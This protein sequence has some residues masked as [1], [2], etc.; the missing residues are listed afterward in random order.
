[1]HGTPRSAVAFVQV[2]LGLLVALVVP[3]LAACTAPREAAPA[4]VAAA[5]GAPFAWSR[6]GLP[7]DLRSADDVRAHLRRGL[8]EDELE[9]IGFDELSIAECIEQIVAALEQERLARGDPGVCARLREWETLYIA[10]VKDASLRRC[11]GA[12]SCI[13]IGR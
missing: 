11:I 4:T 10:V 2:A 8:R 1:M 7:D 6:L 5:T 9:R 12:A 13:P 3:G